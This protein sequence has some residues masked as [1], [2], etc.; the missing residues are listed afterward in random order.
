MREKF[1]EKYKARDILHKAV[2]SG[3]VVPMPCED[4]GAQRVEGHHKDYSKPLDVAWLCI[5]HHRYYHDKEG[6]IAI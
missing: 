6:G 3:K 1:P 2:V 4:C 5:E